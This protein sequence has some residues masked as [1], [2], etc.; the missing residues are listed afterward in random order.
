M[1][2]WDL[3]DRQRGRDR[4]VASAAAAGSGGLGLV[5]AQSE[6]VRAAARS[7]SPRV[8]RPLRL[9]PSGAGARQKDGQRD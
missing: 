1:L 5:V 3:L 9:F 8:V 4:A 2:A 6:L 7:Q